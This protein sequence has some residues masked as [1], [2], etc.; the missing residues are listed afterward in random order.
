[1]A[2]KGASIFRSLD[3]VILRG[4]PVIFYPVPKIERIDL[5]LSSPIQEVM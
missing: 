5:S 3:T 1:M 2:T 4:R